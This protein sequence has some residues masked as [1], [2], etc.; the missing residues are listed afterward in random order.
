M[1]GNGNRGGADG[2]ASD[3]A[4]SVE[5]GDEF[6]LTPRV[7]QIVDRALVYLKTGYPVHFSGP[8]GTGKT[9]LALHLAAL[10]GRA[11]MLMHGDDEFGSSD[12]IGGDYGYQKSKLIDN[13]I[14]SVLKTEE[15]VNTLWADNRLTLACKSGNTLI[16]DEFTRSRPEANNVLLSALEEGLLTLPRRRPHGGDGYL[17]VHPEFR[18]IFTSNPEEYAG[19][20][21][22]QDALMDRLITIKLDYFDR[23]T[24]VKITQAKSGIP[25]KDAEVIVDIVRDLR[26]LGLSK[27]G[28][29]LRACIMIARLTAQQ[30]ARARW[31]DSTFQQVCR[32]VLD[33]HP[34]KVVRGGESNLGEKI[35]E[36]INK[37]ALRHTQMGSV[38]ELVTKRAEQA[39]GK[40]V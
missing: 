33:G 11:V 16:Y 7:Q 14:H 1:N 21:R 5:A 27:H 3:A 18:A 39:V 35:T 30:D 2:V 37:R 31:D 22:T 40:G 9:T 23:Y 26:G 10:R 4:L 8:A 12:L 13:F 38:P 17:E 25:E 32:D 29:S 20:H 15:N 36:L 24:E 28:P 6:V 19:V 34:V